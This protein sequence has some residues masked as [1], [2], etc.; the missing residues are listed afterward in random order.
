MNRLKV[1]AIFGIGVVVGGAGVYYGM[2]ETLKD[3]YRRAVEEEIRQVKDHYKIVHS[4][5]Q[6]ETPEEMLEARREET[7]DEYEKRIAL[8]SLETDAKAWTAADDPAVI[9]YTTRK[10]KE[11]PKMPSEGK[12]YPINFEQFDGE[13]THY[14]KDTLTYFKGDDVVA[15]EN[16]ERIEDIEGIIGAEALSHF[17]EFSLETV[18]VRNDRLSSDFEIVLDKG[19]F[20]EV[21]EGHDG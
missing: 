12:A 18:Y 9:D 2:N 5:D 11:E 21:V 10:P 17:D 7:E 15:D 20:S 3:G 13:E 4:K 14:S 16:D 19:R 6:F 1:A 8:Y